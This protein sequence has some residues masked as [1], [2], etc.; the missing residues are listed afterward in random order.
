VRWSSINNQSINHA[1][2]DAPYVNL[3]KPITG[4]DT[5]SIYDS[6]TLP[7][8]FFTFTVAPPLATTLRF[9]SVRFYSLNESIRFSKKSDRSIRPKLGVCMQYLTVT[10]LSMLQQQAQRQENECKDINLPSP[11][12]H[13]S[14]LNSRV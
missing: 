7:L 4:A 11:L 8:L 6:Y 1:A 10:V 12:P 9:E 14:S 3:K 2:A 5:A 13:F